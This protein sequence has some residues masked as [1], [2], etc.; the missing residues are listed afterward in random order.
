MSQII[1]QRIAQ[2][3]RTRTS[4]WQQQLASFLGRAQV[5]LLKLG[6]AALLAYG[7]VFQTPL[8]W[9]VA[10]P[11]KLTA[12]PRPVDAIVVFGGGVGES[13]RPGKGHEERVA[14]AVALYHEGYAPR[15]VFSSGFVRVFREPH[16]MR[17]LAMSLGVPAEAIILE[18]QAAST[19]DNVRFV[20]EI[21]KTQGMSSILLVSSPY[22]MRRALMVFQRQA[23]WVAVVP[24]PVEQNTFY[25]HHWGAETWQV[26]GIVHEYLAIVYYW[27]MGYL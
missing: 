8:L 26:K 7:L 25:A 16:V 24:A 13:G 12:A 17:V 11:L 21:L 5:R 23:P 3:E 4:N 1:E 18:E 9:L 19:Y 20:S 15:L 27:W 22:H 10:V 14:H 2:R 6:L